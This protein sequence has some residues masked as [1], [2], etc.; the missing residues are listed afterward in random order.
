MR[1][2]GS[3][4]PEEEVEEDEERDREASYERDEGV[5]GEEEEAIDVDTRRSLMDTI[6]SWSVDDLLNKDLYR[7]KVPTIPESFSSSKQYFNAFFPPLLE[8]VHA[9]IPC[10]LEVVSEASIFSVLRIKESYMEH[11]S[12]DKSEIYEMS[13]DMKQT[14][15]ANLRTEMHTPKRADIIL[16]SERIRP[17]NQ[18]QIREN[19]SSCTLGWVT[20]VE[21]GNI[22]HVRASR[23]INIVEPTTKK[24]NRHKPSTE[25][26][27]VSSEWVVN[28]GGA[29]SSSSHPSVVENYIKQASKTD[30]AFNV[31]ENEDN[32]EKTKESKETYKYN[33]PRFQ[34]FHVVFLSNMT[35]YQRTWRALD[36]GLTKSSRIIQ[37]I[38]GRKTSNEFNGRCTCSNRTYQKAQDEISNFNLNA[39]QSKAAASCISASDCRCTSSVELV[40]GPPGTGKTRTIGAI[41]KLLLAKTC[42]TLTCAPTNTAIMQ[43]ASNLLSLVNKS[44]GCDNCYL[45]DVV[46]F[47]NKDRLKVDDELSSIYL[48]ERV[49]RLMVFFS[50]QTELKYKLGIM[51]DFLL[52]P[53][54]LYQNFLGL[55][56]RTNNC[57]LTF[58]EYLS[59]RFNSL[60]KDLKNY[61][62]MLRN[63]LPSSLF[64]KNGFQDIDLVQDM[65]DE[66]GELLQVTS[67][68]ENDLGEAFEK[69]NEVKC[70][71]S[72]SSNSASDN[73][74][75]HGDS[76]LIL[77]KKK[78]CSCL[79]TLN[80][81]SSRNLKHALPVK[82]D[83]RSIRNY[84]IREAK[85]LF[86]TVS[87]A[88]ELHERRMDPIEMLVIDEA[89]QLKECESLIPLQL[90][91][92]RHVYLIGDEN[93]LAAFVQSEI[94]RNAAFG[95]SLFERLILTEHRKHL[96]NVQYRMHPHINDFPNKK[97]YQA[98][99]SNGS[100]VKTEGYSRT[101]LE[102]PMYGTYSFIHLVNNEETFDQL[103]HSPKNLIEVE[104]VDHII[105]R[106]ANALQTAGRHVNVGIISPYA[107]QIK[108]IQ[109]RLGTRYLKHKFI[110]VK[111]RSVDGFQGGE[112]D[113]ILMSTV[114][115]NRDG[116]IGF[117]CD[118]RRI[119]VALTRAKYCLWILGNESTLTKSNSIWKD[120]VLDAK[121]RKCFF[122]GSDD[123][124]LAE[125]IEG[126]TEGLTKAGRRYNGNKFL[127]NQ[128]EEKA[129]ETASQR[130]GLKQSGRSDVHSRISWPNHCRETPRIMVARDG[131][132]YTCPTASCNNHQSGPP[133]RGLK[134]RNRNFNEVVCHG[135]VEGDDRGNDKSPRKKNRPHWRKRLP[136][137]GAEYDP[138]PQ[139]ETRGQSSFVLSRG[140]CQVKP[141]TSVWDR[142]S[143][144]GEEAI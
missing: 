57:N 2:D 110:S 122:N 64:T 118:N 85:L 80:D 44:E 39:S 108:A 123:A 35:T 116:D 14:M 43:V 131:R 23:K 88:Y 24:E 69:S 56:R 144:Y 53:P 25:I 140:P 42:R 86:C 96:L 137:A 127:D 62:A 12:K 104:V 136:M 15:K 28:I 81:I 112:A 117:M 87:S 1:Y 66:I 76:E 90:A 21:R 46:L 20:G 77:L 55:K 19:A 26:E 32:Q 130:R 41:L 59:D 106:L 124:N 94:T 109:D 92:I 68:S 141:S 143:G 132:A 63:D 78:I 139:G 51:I 16:I 120:L 6:L 115:S 9:D 138:V 34:S 54:S 5:D 89:A 67:L 31:M 30:E 126:A 4:Y 37:S 91:N 10:N 18:S 129:E 48:D 95:R 74:S 135:D 40:Q 58:R 97:F 101:Y 29:S 75:G 7:D 52:N 121:S 72:D 22:L 107:A 84:C 49:K 128:H 27:S 133:R 125:M 71:D 36:M 13:I 93:Q 98:R 113:V 70:W 65:V 102:G 114:R 105:K 45:G 103:G 99:I 17:Q 38:L 47:G 73:F 83:E 33:L 134:K 3:C 142:L 82:F 61:I 60:V 50:S 100:N 11:Q 119:N 79:E 8:E 111:V